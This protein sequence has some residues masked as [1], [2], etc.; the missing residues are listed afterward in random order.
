MPVN[1]AKRVIFVLGMHRSGTSSLAGALDACGVWLG[2]DLIGADP[3]INAKGYWEH[4]ELVRINEALL[5]ACG[6]RWFYPEA[7]REVLLHLEE[8]VGQDCLES[9]RRFVEQIPV[10]GQVFAIKDP[11]LCLTA[12][13]WYERFREQGFEVSIIHLLRSHREVARSLEKRDAITPAHSNALWLDYVGAA[14]EFIRDYP[15]EFARTEFDSFLANPVEEM[16]S[17]VAEARLPFTVDNKK[18]SSWVEPGLR[19]HRVQD[20]DVNE[21]W[22][23]EHAASVLNAL[24]GTRSQR[25]A[26]DIDSPHRWSAEERSFL[27]DLVTMF[28]RYNRTLIQLQETARHVEELGALH[29]KALARIR[30]LDQG[31]AHLASEKQVLESENEALNRELISAQQTISSRD[32]RVQLMESLLGPIGRYRLRRLRA[33]N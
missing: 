20:T 17:L 21:D 16:E 8:G 5:E 12:P 22:R 23:G 29:D 18:L 9:S 10:E 32:E 4:R 6:Q 26:C 2:D 27:H 30:E 24:S 31:V 28:E 11:R 19:H 7:S 14:E 25:R 1:Q 3:E 15:V 13:F 33:E